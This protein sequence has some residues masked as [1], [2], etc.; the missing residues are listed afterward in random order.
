M[1]RLPP[2]DYCN[3]DIL[4][5]ASI[6]PHCGKAVGFPNVRAAANLDERAALDAR[7]GEARSESASRK[8]DAALSSFEKA[9]SDAKAVIVRSTG[10]LQR[11]ASSDNEVYATY[12]QLTEAVVRLP[13]GD[14]WD[15]LRALADSALFPGY[16][17][18][19]RFAALS[20]DGHGLYSYGECSMIL[21]TEMIEDRASLFEENTVL[22]MKNHN[23]R[24]WGAESLP[25]GYRAI[26]ADKAK[27]CAAKLHK[28]IDATTKADEYCDLL[29]KQGANSEEDEFVEVHIYGPMTARTIERVRF[30]QRRK[31]KYS[32][33]I[34]KAIKQKLAK[35]GVAVE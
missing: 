6:C 24:I 35:L 20:L 13:R 19:I 22:F 4:P 10:E 12:Y 28:R 9:L 23:V 2:C 7:Y 26:W 34:S 3:N 1:S 27:L 31:S 11:L 15:V 33:I 14:K 8:A 29:L 25:K 18:N 17:E 16:K 5:S 32:G 30:S 21:R